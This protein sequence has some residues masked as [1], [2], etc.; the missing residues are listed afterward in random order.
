MHGVRS[1]LE[2]RSLLQGSD[3]LF[4]YAVICSFMQLI[5]VAASNPVRVAT[6]KSGSTAS[7]SP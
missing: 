5:A 6:S 1:S 3:L 2:Q 7:E 4:R